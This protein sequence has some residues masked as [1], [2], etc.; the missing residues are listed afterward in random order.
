MERTVLTVFPPAMSCRRSSRKTESIK[1]YW[2][3]HLC[4]VVYSC[5]A[6]ATCKRRLE[7][8]VV[9]L[10]NLWSIC[11]WRAPTCI[12]EPPTQR[13][14]SLSRPLL[15]IV[16]SKLYW[17]QLSRDAGSMLHF[18]YSFTWSRVLASNPWSAAN[19]IFGIKLFRRSELDTSW[20][21]KMSFSS[22]LSHGSF[23][24]VFLAVCSLSTSWSPWI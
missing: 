10:A 22:F 14:R 13:K 24:F 17:S 7:I 23:Q 12:S 19:V 1:K 5:F 4:A 9:W 6:S 3:V 20:P 16:L 15:C 21:A 18:L 11:N 2:Q 8:I